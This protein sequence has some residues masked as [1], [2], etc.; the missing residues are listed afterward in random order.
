MIVSDVETEKNLVPNQLIK[1]DN[2]TI[3]THPLLISAGMSPLTFKELIISTAN[4]LENVEFF[5]RRAA[6]PSMV[7]NMLEKMFTFDRDADIWATTEDRDAIAPLKSNT[8]A[9]AIFG[10]ELL[11]PALIMTLIMLSSRE[12]AFFSKLGIFCLFLFNVAFVMMRR[13]VATH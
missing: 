1:N 8:A 4:M 7:T 6:M 11:M 13:P 2:T 3:T 10:M 5:E 12:V 9:I